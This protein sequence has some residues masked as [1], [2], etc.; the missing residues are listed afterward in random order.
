M[1][2]EIASTEP[3]RLAVILAFAA[4]YIIWG[5][6]YL[7]ISYAIKT[8]PPML[9]VGIRFS[10]AGLLLFTWCTL[11]NKQPLPSVKTLKHGAL[12]GFLLLFIGN[13]SVVLAEQHIASGLTAI[14]V[15]AVPLWM[16]LLDK[17]HWATSFQHPRVILGLLIGFGGVI[18]LVTAGG[19][20][21][22][23]SISNTPQ[24]LSM[25]L[26]IAGS[27]SWAGGSLYS[28]YHVAEGSTFMK[29]SLQMLSAGILF[30]I[31]SSLLGEPAHLHL[32][33][34][35]I[36]SATGLIYLITFGSLIGYLCYIWLLSVQPASKVG[37]Y[38][39]VN[40]IVAVLLGWLIASDPLSI[41]QFFG[42]GVILAGVMLVNSKH[43]A[44]KPTTST[45]KSTL[46]QQT[47]QPAS[48]KS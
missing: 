12:S 40:P 3:S 8:I 43:Q 35:S 10:V 25:L 41:G 11:F 23:F 39:Y 26:L 45:T 13:G 4:V 29:V 1:K 34:V 2:R 47:P 15:A 48:S 6:T 36:P 32:N 27:I 24:L 9:M 30:I 31:I 37:T 33:Q 21:M 44:H 17:K 28:K 46:P 19:A 16:V 38:A 14:I 7:S 22:N 42:L 18:F 20:A 5:S